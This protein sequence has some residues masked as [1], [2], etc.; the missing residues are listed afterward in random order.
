MYIVRVTS[1]MGRRSYLNLALIAMC[2]RLCCERSFHTCD[3]KALKVD[4]RVRTKDRQMV[5]GLP[6]A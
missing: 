6:A 3:W 1:S 4:R 2:M 5:Q